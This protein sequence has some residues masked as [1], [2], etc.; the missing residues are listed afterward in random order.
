MIIFNN[1][2]T[3][4]ESVGAGQLCWWWGGKLTTWRYKP[5]DD[6]Q[7]SGETWRLFACKI[8]LNCSML[9]FDRHWVYFFIKITLLHHGIVRVLNQLLVTVWSWS[10]C[11]SWV[12]SSEV[13]TW[14]SVSPIIVSWSVSWHDSL[15]QHSLQQL[16]PTSS[17]RG[18]AGA[19][20]C[21]IRVT[22]TM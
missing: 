10:T 13:C 17:V 21:W 11:F 7:C 19:G 3:R 2:I 5:G 6:L 16:T 18:A 12:L 4:H 8:H 22:T 1:D 14:T 15:V 20:H 9:K